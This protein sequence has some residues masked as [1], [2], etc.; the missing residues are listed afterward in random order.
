MADHDEELTAIGAPRI[1]MFKGAADN[2]S[3][4]FAST[5]TNIFKGSIVDSLP[6]N[7]LGSVAEPPRIHYEMPE[8]HIDQSPSETAANTRAM[9]EYTAT[10][11]ERMQDLVDVVRADLKVSQDMRDHAKAATDAANRSGLL[12]LIIAWVSGIATVASLVVAIIA[13]VIAISSTQ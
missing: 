9:A 8:I 4:I 12:A 7:I 5:G 1:N 11:T 3:K 10:M 2:I 13:L 6:T